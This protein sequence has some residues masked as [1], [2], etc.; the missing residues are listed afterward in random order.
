MGWIGFSLL[1][2]AT[3]TVT[4]DFED[5]LRYVTTTGRYMTSF[6]DARDE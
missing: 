5:G 1:Q 3:V 6:W 4:A 2:V